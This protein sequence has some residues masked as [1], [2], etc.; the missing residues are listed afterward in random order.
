MRHRLLTCL[1]SWFLLFLPV[2]EAQIPDF[3]VI[4][5][6]DFYGLRIIPESRIQ[7]LLPFKEGDS[8]PQIP[9]DSLRTGMPTTLG[10]TKVEI[11]LVCC[12]NEGL[13]I[14]YVGVEEQSGN[15]PKYHAAPA[16]EVTLPPEVEHSYEES[17]IKLMEVVQS[18][19]GGEDRSH[20][21]SLSE[22]APLRSIQENFIAYAAHYHD[23]LRQVLHETANAHHRAIAAHVLG[24]AQAKA[25]ITDELA[26]AVQD[27]AD[28]VRNNA[29][30]ALAVIAEYANANP[31]QGIKIQPDPF[32]DM[33]NSVVWSDRNKALAV[34][35][36]LTEKRDIAILQR[37]RERSL[38]SL[39]EM[40]RWQ[41][42]G[43]AASACAI[44]R[45]IV[46]LPDDADPKSKTET[47]HGRNNCVSEMVTVVI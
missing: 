31:E 42:L 1:A 14:V 7:A 4:G 12:D 44:L 2:A 41:N 46:G 35:I 30:R 37:L 8:P 23:L 45:R 40:C 47:L 11:S 26:W 38:P 43:H 15:T 6:V 36:S 27:P 28:E 39:I 13:S 33:L 9:L 32:I 24:Y 29:T 10:V 3:P 21:H 25:G 34:L 19:K 17:M 16:G 18:G 5:T 22:Y 20:G